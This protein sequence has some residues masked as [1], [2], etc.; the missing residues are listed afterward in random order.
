MEF[1]A[2][3]T[4]AIFYALSLPEYRLLRAHIQTR[5]QEEHDAW[6]RFNGQR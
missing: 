6:E 1:Y 4:P 3:M 2:G 5:R